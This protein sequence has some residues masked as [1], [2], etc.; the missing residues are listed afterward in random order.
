MF[1]GQLDNGAVFR[2]A[3]AVG[4]HAHGLRHP[5]V[6]LQHPLLAVQRD[7]EP[8][9][10]QG[11]DDL[12]LLLAGVAG[13]MQHIRLVIH[14]VGPLAE[15]LV[16]DPAHRHLIAGNGGGGNNDLVLGADV[17]LLM[18][19]EGHAV[20]GAHLLALAAGGDDHLLLGRQALDAVDVHHRALGQLHIPQLRGHLHDVLHAAAGDGH[21]PPAGRRRV[22][23]VQ[24]AGILLVDKLQNSLQPP[25]IG[26]LGRGQVARTPDERR[27]KQQ[28]LA[29]DAELV[30]DVL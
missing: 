8:G 26:G 6:D 16:D 3:D 11:V 21:L 27:Q 14:H 28:Q 2:H 25:G 19:G 15:Q 13:H 18:G 30:A 24:L 5:L 1:G 23:D 9:L 10:G 12:Q 20:Q 22:G 7:E 4:I 17:D 29:L